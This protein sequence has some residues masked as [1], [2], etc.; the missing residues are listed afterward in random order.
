[1]GKANGRGVR[2]NLEDF[3]LGRTASGLTAALID[4]LVTDHVEV[5]GG[6]RW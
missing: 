4:P 2:A 1:M 5:Y 6:A 3:P